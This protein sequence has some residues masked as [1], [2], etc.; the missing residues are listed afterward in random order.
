MELM[1]IVKKWICSAAACLA[2]AGA[3]MATPGNVVISQA[4]GG[5]GNTGSTYRNDF[6]EIYNRSNAPVS[7]AGWSVQYASSAGTTWSVTA[8]GTGAVTTLAPGQYYLIQEAVGAG[9]TTNL[10]TPDATGTISMGSGGFKVALVSNTTALTGA[11][12]TGTGSGI[13]DFVGCSSGANGF[14]TAFA[15][16]PSNTNAVI[17]NGSGC[18][19]T[20]NNSTDFVAA[21]AA[22]RNSASTFGNCFPVVNGA[23][24]DTLGGCTFVLSTA[25]TGTYQGDNV[26][27][28]PC[29]ATQGACCTG[30]GSCFLTAPSGCTGSS[31]F[32]AMGTACAA[33]NCGQY[34][35]ACCSNSD[36]TCFV[37]FPASCLGGNTASALGTTCSPNN[38]FQPS[39]ACCADN[40]AGGSCSIQPAN[41][42]P[43]GFWL[44]MNSTCTA[45]IC[46]PPAVAISQ[47]YGAGGN[48][49]AVYQQDYVELF[50]RSASSVDV[51]GWT[52]QYASS[53]GTSWQRT[54][55]ITGSNTVIAPGQ[56]FLVLMTATG[57][58]GT[59]LTGSADFISTSNV[60]ASA[61]SGKV[62]LVRTGSL[63]SAVAC[64][65]GEAVLV[66]FIGYGTST[67]CF[68]GT[69]PAP[70]LG[71]TTAAL[72]AAHGCQDSN[73]NSAD[74]TAG[75]P[76][77][78]NSLNTFNCNAPTVTVT[79][80]PDAIC[81]GTSTTITATVTSGSNPASTSYTVTADLTNIGGG[82]AVSFTGSAPTFTLSASPVGAIAQGS[83][84]IVVTVKDQLNRTA[85]ASVNLFT[86][87]CTN[88]TSTVVISQVYGG[89][90]NTG[91]VYTNDF[92]ELFN[93]S[94]SSVDLTGWSVQYASATDSGGGFVAANVTPLSGSIAG[95]GYYLIRMAPGAGGTTALPT[96]DAIGTVAM[97][98]SSGRVALTN[99][100]V[101]ISTICNDPSVKDLVGY[102]L[103]AACFEGD[104]AIGPVSDLSNTT[105]ALR[106]QNGCQDTDQ[107]K[108]DFDIAAAAPRNSASPVNL[109]T[110]VASGVCCR[111]ATCNSTVGQGSCTGNTLAGAVFISSASACNA[112]GNT[113]TPCC[114]PD[115]N[116]IGGITVGDI[117]D[118]LNDWFSGSPF[119]IVGGNGTPGALAVQNIFDFLNA[120]FAGGC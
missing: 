44:G 110:P 96:P 39:G 64:H 119:A 3:A 65:T 66:D 7:I 95:G 12:A 58:N 80:S 32:T 45:G 114:Y 72:R 21:A 87:P 102:G 89:G 31:V 88:S 29:V 60:D 74:F 46:A 69:N 30:S 67:N 75:T 48:S 5:G 27:C 2:F 25:C 18:T 49:G 33:A 40:T 1:S 77:P 70:G 91:A 94:S 118:F 41:L 113:T 9:G 50:N 71:A 62:A 111:G 43:A 108:L 116:K 103:S 86:S 101:A 54:S 92:V 79:L 56:Y 109:C 112:G 24:C 85:T 100:T 81:N 6:I 28:N 107:N 59:D 51:S 105:A 120:W 68:E 99:S 90:G 117:F 52:I 63:L 8:I 34:V 17:R 98:A 104:A 36:G 47:F 37:A 19:D 20:D 23:C 82:S 16:A 57:T 93:R 22:P 35:A 26:A 10:P 84:S 73:D 61:S 13:V 53:T 106:R 4:Y 11:V 38:C 14:E 115:Y 97:G 42:C 15:P 78:H 55:P 83:H 76:G